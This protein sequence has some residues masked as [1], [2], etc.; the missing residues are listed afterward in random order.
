VT[1]AWMGLVAGLWCAVAVLAAWVLRL[2]WRVRE[3]TER[4][5][6]GFAPFSHEPDDDVTLGPRVGATID[7]EPLASPAPGGG[8]RRGRI[9]LFMNSSCSPSHMLG[10][11]LIA[12]GEDGFVLVGS[13]LVL[14]TDELGAAFYRGLGA[15]EVLVQPA[16]EISRHLGIIA[17]PYG[18]A[19]DGTG[20][21]RWSG[22]V[23]NFDDVLAMVAAFG[24]DA[25]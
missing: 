21:V 15:D 19:I 8:E 1:P 14:V 10:D 11:E 2:T 25:H 7:L 16:N 22:L 23:A 12:A 24:M 13:D 20:V 3:L 9:V 4:R 17:T 5:G 6:G 18:I